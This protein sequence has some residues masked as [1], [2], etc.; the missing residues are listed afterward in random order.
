MSWHGI[1]Q[2]IFSTYITHFKLKVVISS[3]S[4]T[5][6]IPT[7]YVAMSIF[8]HVHYHITLVLLLSTY[9]SGLA[10]FNK[11]TYVCKNVTSILN[12]TTAATTALCFSFFTLVIYG[13]V[14]VPRVWTWTIGHR[15][16]TLL[17]IEYEM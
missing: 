16:G 5:I 14:L 6:Y 15:H 1:N 2:F 13:V 9:H 7:T 3:Y 17:N 4:Y 10:N 8:C 11:N 12:L